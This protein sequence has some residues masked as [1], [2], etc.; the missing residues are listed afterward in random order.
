LEEII[1]SDRLELLSKQL[2]LI[3]YSQDWGIA[4]A[5]AS[6]LDG[7]LDFY[8][9]HIPDDSF[10]L[11]VLAELIFQSAEEAI[12]IGGL[13]SVDVGRLA[14]FIRKNQSSFPQTLEYW[15]N[16]ESGNW[17][18]PTLIRETLFEMPIRKKIRRRF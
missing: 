15:R 5:D 8:D 11:E 16:L 13:E 2:G 6:R 17:R 4:N 12:A 7:F 3:P 14:S 10:E 9:S 1:K 18:L